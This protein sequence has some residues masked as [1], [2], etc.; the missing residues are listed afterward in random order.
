MRFALLGD[1]PDGLDMARALAESGRHALTVY[2]GPPLGAEQLAR[3]NL[4]PL[5]VGDVEEVLA[6]PHIDAIIVA[7]IAASRPALLRR[8]LQS[9]R[10]VLCVHPAGDTPDLAHEASMIQADTGR[11]LFPLLPEALHPALRRFAGLASDDESVRLLQFER[12]STE[13]LSF[14]DGDER[15]PGLPDWD[16]LRAVGGEI[17]ELFAV[18]GTE[19]YLLPG[20][21]LV[22]AGRFIDGLLFH[23][24]F[25][26]RQARERWRLAT[27]SR[28]GPAILD[29]PD[30]WPGTARLTRLDTDGLPQIEEWPAFHPWAALVEAF[31]QALSDDVAPVTWHDELRSLELDDAVRRSIARRRSS[32]LEYQEATEEAGFKGTMTLVGCGLLWFSVVL[33]IMAVWWPM[34]GWFIAPVFGVFLLL[35]VFRWAIP[36]RTPPANAEADAARASSQER[37]T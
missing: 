16:V 8:A 28:T 1:H 30:G 23:A 7:S 32:T 11:L 6:D 34:L 14:G 12:W 36:A 35:Q 2:A 18:A 33:L 13:E 25:L 24:T 22:V 17:A 26:P 27:I 10:H 37:S 31:D 21:P 4:R 19:E 15:K 9:E 3:W 20:D 5:Q 29:F